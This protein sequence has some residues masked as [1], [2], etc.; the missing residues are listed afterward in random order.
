MP[1]RAEASSSSLV[2]LLST[3]ACHDARER[4]LICRGA[5]DIFITTQLQFA[6]TPSLLGIAAFG[7]ASRPGPRLTPRAPRRIQR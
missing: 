3:L 7:A 4:M 5:D 6:S 2:D 1:P